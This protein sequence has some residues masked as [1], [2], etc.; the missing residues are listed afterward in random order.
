MYL[1]DND[2][3]A[4]DTE[5]NKNAYYYLFDIEI[6]SK[7]GYLIKQLDEFSFYFHR[8]FSLSN[9][10]DSKENIMLGAKLDFKLSETVNLKLDM[11]RVYYDINQ[12]AE[13][14]K[15]TSLNS[16][17]TYN[18]ARPSDIIKRRQQRK[19]ENKFILF[20]LKHNFGKDGAFHELIKRINPFNKKDSEPND[21]V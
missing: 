8:N 2:R 1:I 6:F 14:D 3:Y 5:D 21:E 10:E 20:N 9:I 17:F 13:V 15:V 4:D 16:H 19:S 18:I 7:N 11:Q 12:D